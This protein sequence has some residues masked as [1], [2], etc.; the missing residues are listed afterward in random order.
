MAGMQKLPYNRYN[1]LVSCAYVWGNPKFYQLIDAIGDYCNILIDSGAFTVFW[2]ELRAIAGKEKRDRTDFF[3]DYLRDCKEH[4]HGRVWQYIALDVI[5]N[6]TGTMKNLHEM[7]D[8]GLRPMPVYVEGASE[9]DLSYCLDVA[10][11]RLCVAGGVQTNDHYIRNR[12]KEVKRISGGRSKIHG[13]GFGRW[14]D[15]FQLPIASADSSSYATGSMWGSI[16]IYSRLDGFIN[17]HH[18]EI[19]KPKPGKIDKRIK[20]L[21]FLIEKCGVKERDL[22]DPS[23]LRTHVGIPHLIGQYAYLLFMQ[24]CS[25]AGVD[26][27]VAAPSLELATSLIVH[28]YA[29][30]G[31]QFD[32]YAAREK[33]LELRQLERTNFSAALEFYAD[34]L[35][36]KTN[37]EVLPHSL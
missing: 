29:T 20:I 21:R 2:E 4:F 5:R 11:G 12:Y 33:R 10:G 36:K 19:K 9:A 15:I 31:D 34:T 23:F 28:L 24:H 27:F 17:I 16:T 30:D 6:P 35:Q 8:G 32:F 13:L 26:Y 1:L 25:E 3:Q 18:S 14:P 22:Y 37:Q 7:V